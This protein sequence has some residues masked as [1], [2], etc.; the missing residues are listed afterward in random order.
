VLL[1]VARQVV[2][3]RVALTQI[4]Q[5]PQQTLLRYAE[6]QKHV[7]HT[8]FV[9]A[10][11]QNIVR[12]LHETHRH[13]AS[14]EKPTILSVARTTNIKKSPVFIENRVQVVG[15]GGAR[16]ARLESVVA[17]MRATLLQLQTSGAFT[18][19][20]SLL[21]KQPRQVLLVGDSLLHLQ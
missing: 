8:H 17:E 13:V 9:D 15:A 2:K 16:L 18:Q 19:P 12:H 20:S 5:A 11:Q 4:L 7:N 10:R 6:V 14:V 1:Q 21:I 3:K